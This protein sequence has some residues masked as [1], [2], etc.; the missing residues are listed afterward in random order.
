VLF[1]HSALQQS[2]AVWQAAPETAQP[3]R[4]LTHWLPQQ[5]DATRHEEPSRAQVLID[6]QVWLFGSHTSA[7]QQ[8][9]LV[10]HE[11]AAVAQPQAPFTH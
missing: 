5:S 4:L 8:S 6:T 7:P 10:W 3:Q 1:T 11:D 2:L 9:R